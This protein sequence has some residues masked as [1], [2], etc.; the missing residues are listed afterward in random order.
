[1]SMRVRV[2]GQR[3]FNEHESAS[4]CRSPF[5]SMIVREFGQRLL[6]EHDSASFW[7]ET[8]V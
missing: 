8:L 6:Y 4:I 5:M 7:S 1:M 3:L 2:F